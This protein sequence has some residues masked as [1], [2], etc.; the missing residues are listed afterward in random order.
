MAKALYFGDNLEVLCESIKGE[1]VDLVYL[2]PPFN[3][4]TT[5]NVLFKTPKG[6]DSDAQIEALDDTWQVGVHAEAAFADVMQGPNTDV[7]EVI[8]AMRSVLGENNMNP[9]PV[10]IIVI[11]KVPVTEG[12]EPDERA[13]AELAPERARSARTNQAAW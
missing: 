4:N 3:S 12:G 6:H 1:W 8:R 5:Y 13:L 9:V 11:A 7:A 2:D 10:T